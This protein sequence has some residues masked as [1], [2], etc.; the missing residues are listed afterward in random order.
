VCVVGA[1]YSDEKVVTFVG[2]DHGRFATPADFPLR[3]CSLYSHVHVRRES[4]GFVHR[5]FSTAP[6]QTL[7]SRFAVY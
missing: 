1:E 6:C 3:D 5:P 7:A 4:L 2:W